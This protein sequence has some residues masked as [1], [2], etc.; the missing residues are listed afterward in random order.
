M[1]LLPHSHQLPA[2]ILLLPLPRKLL[3]PLTFLLHL[4]PGLPILALILKLL[5]FREDEHL[6]AVG[7]LHAL[8]QSVVVELQ[9]LVVVEYLAHFLLLLG[10]LEDV[11]TLFVYC[12]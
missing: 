9:L 3:L 1:Y 6:I 12:L 11:C 10:V 5:E 2:L 8:H 4:H 7:F